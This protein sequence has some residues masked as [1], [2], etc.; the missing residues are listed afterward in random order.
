MA[1]S[2]G[3]GL[4]TAGRVGVSARGVVGAAVGMNMKG[5]SRG[6]LRLRLGVGSVSTRTGGLSWAG[7]PLCENNIGLLGFCQF[8]KYYSRVLVVTKMNI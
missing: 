3:G 8:L 5:F 7:G 1:S 2:P 4:P 6:C